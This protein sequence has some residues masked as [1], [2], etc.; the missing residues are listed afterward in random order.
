VADT[1]INSNAVK[2][3]WNGDAIRKSV[4]DGVWT[5]LVRSGVVLQKSMQTTL[6]VKGGFGNRSSP[7]DPPRVD[8]NTLR[9][10][11]STVP[12]EANRVVRVGTN[13]PHGRY[14]EFGAVIRP[15]KT[16]YLP[17]PL[18]KR[19]AQML[20]KDA[21]RSGGLRTQNLALITSKGEAYLIEQTPSGKERK[22][23]AAFALK[24]QVTIKPRPWVYRSYIKARNDMMLVFQVAV[25]DAI[26]KA[27]GK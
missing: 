19:A 10:S 14:M 20:R 23:G 2:L 4:E 3:R 12:D 1:P 11:I 7:G 15:K 27:V 6:G 5:G 17:I 22:N 24:K 16:K 18:N 13:V 9:K 25:R 8:S 26:T 21:V